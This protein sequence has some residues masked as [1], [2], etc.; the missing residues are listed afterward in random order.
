MSHGLGNVCKMLMSH[1]VAA[2]IDCVYTMS[3]QPQASRVQIGA[4][5]AAFA[6]ILLGYETHETFHARPL[7]KTDCDRMQRLLP[8]F[9]RRLITHVAAE[10]ACTETHGLDISART[11]Y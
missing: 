7:G 9:P 6:I 10:G 2:A 8:E 4:I 5:R 1:S 11:Q 3:R